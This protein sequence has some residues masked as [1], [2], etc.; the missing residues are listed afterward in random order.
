MM[1]FPDKTSMPPR[2]IRLLNDVWE[3]ISS[4]AARQGLE[5]KRA[6]LRG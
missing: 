2:H 5:A 3:D 6:D 4:Q 1:K